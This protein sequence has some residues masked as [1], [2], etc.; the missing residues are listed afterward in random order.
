MSEADRIRRTYQDYKDSPRWSG[1]NPG[2]QYNA[3]MRNQAIQELL[4]G[5]GML[6]LSGK[7]VLE[8]G[9]GAGGNL[10]S[11]ERFGARRADLYGIDL[12]PEAVQAARSTFPGIHFSPGNGEALEFADRTFDL[13]LLFIVFSSILDDGV[14]SRV[15]AEAVRVLRPG[16][17]VLW[18]DI[19]YANPMNRRVR[20]IKRH[21][22]DAWFPGLDRRTRTITLLPQIARR[23]GPLTG[24]LS[25]VLT[26]VPP[27]RTHYLCLMRKP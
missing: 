6:P 16:G 25:P 22:L 13:I 3:R 9:S 5:G 23:L 20:P 12:R 8:I 2:N 11:L 18:Y 21:Q 26:A 10:A 24:L 4:A 17:A 27:L 7:R 1:R 14:A 19:R 15:A